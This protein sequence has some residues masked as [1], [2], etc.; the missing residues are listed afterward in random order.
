MG[1]QFLDIFL[2]ISLVSHTDGETSPSSDDDLN[3]GDQITI[4]K[5]TGGGA[6]EKTT[7][8]VATEEPESSEASDDSE[9]SNQPPSE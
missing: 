9:K 6:M 8:T 3:S 5:Y 7:A 4:Y 1:N 2:S